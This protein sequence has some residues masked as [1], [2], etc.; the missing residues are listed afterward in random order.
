MR[1]CDEEELAALALGDPIDAAAA[2]HAAGCERCATE[3]EDLRAVAGRVQGAAGVELVAPPARVWTAIE[4]EIAADP[5]SSAVKVDEGDGV[6]EGPAVE[7][8]DELARRRE[9]RSPW[10]VGIAAA[11]AGAIIG[12]V[13]VGLVVSGGD[14]GGGTLVAQ[15]PLADLAT[16]A[17]AGSARVERRDD[18]TEVLVLDTPVPAA[19]DANLEVWLIDTDVVGMVSL[20]FLTGDHQEFE[21]PAGYD[22]ADFPIVDVSVE[23]SDGDPTHSGDSVTR[24]VLG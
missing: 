9:R 17:P 22:V 18:G 2:A 20:G 3:V 7:P 12:G 15:A 19:G 5:R 6:D 16:D 10:V 21:I 8:E 14:D 24:G 4:A 23:P 11:A 1:H 13:A